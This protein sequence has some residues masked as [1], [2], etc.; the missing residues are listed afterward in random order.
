MIKNIFFKKQDFEE[1]NAIK[2]HDFERKFI[3]KKH[4]FEEKILLKS[5]FLKNFCAENITFWFIL[6]RK[7]RNFHVLRAILK[8]TILRAKF[9]SKKDDF[10]DKSIFKKHDL[11]EKI[12]FKKHDF[13]WKIFVESMTFN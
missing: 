8:N 3:L 1:K 12:F 13:E 6:P 10:E 5:R 4:D 2:K 9:F 11:E 7:M